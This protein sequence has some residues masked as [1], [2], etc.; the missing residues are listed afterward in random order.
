MQLASQLTKETNQVWV[1]FIRANQEREQT[2]A[3]LAKF[4]AN[5]FVREKQAK[6]DMS[7][8]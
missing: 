4:G 6:K 1:K 7:S 2:R 5:L 3:N 8:L